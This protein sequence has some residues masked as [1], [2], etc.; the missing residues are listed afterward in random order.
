ME[1]SVT[2]NGGSDLQA[3]VA[4]GLPSERGESFTYTH[5]YFKGGGNKVNTVCVC[6]F[7]FCV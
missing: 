7:V 1:L 2:T 5:K 3:P 4:G 6:L